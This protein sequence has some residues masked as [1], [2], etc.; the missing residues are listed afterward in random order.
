MT[1][2]PFPLTPDKMLQNKLYLSADYNPKTL[3][4][5]ILKHYFLL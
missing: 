2:L 1:A 3:P 5:V 4:L